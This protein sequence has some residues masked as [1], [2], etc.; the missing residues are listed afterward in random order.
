MKS[1]TYPVPTRKFAY[2]MLMLPYVSEAQSRVTITTCARTTNAQ[3]QGDAQ[4]PDLKFTRTPLMR[5]TLTLAQ[6]WQMTH[7]TK[8]HSVNVAKYK[9]LFPKSKVRKLHT[10][11]RRGQRGDWW[12]IKVDKWNLICHYKFSFS[13]SDPQ[14]KT[15][16]EALP[17]HRFL[18]TKNLKNWNWPSDFRIIFIKECLQT[19]NYYKRMGIGRMWPSQRRPHW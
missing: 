15:S 16:S 12:L 2:V 5:K 14:K 9:H 17:S 6:T 8:W 11:G 7:W 3:K 19:W 4:K 18:V 13:R 10:K 1:N